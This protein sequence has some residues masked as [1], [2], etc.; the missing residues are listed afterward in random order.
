MVT[1]TVAGANPAISD[2]FFPIWTFAC[3]LLPLASAQLY[4]YA[5]EKR[6]SRLKL[7]SVMGLTPFLIKI[8]DGEA[9]VF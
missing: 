4:F 6:S 9:I 7:I 3:F 2:P 1:G 8:I 5:S